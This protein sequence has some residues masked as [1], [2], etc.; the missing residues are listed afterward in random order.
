MSFI[1]LRNN[2]FWMVNVLNLP[3][4]NVSRGGD[5]S[6]FAHFLGEYWTH[7]CF[8]GSRTKDCYALFWEFC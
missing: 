2:S 6:F 3:V 7:T 1:S 5:L 4:D 8:N